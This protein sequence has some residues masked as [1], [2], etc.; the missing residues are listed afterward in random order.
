MTAAPDAKSLAGA[1]QWIRT[2]LRYR[3]KHPALV[4]VLD[5]VE[6]LMERPYR[7]NALL[8]GPAGSGKE[9]LARAI[10]ALMHAERDGAA[11]IEVSLAGRELHEVLAELCG[12]ASGPGQIERADGGTLYIDEIGTLGREV[13]ARVLAAVRGRVRREGERDERRVSVAVV[14]STDVDIEREVVAGRFRHDLYWRIARI[15]LTLPPLAERQADIARTA[16]WIGNRVLEKLGVDRALS[17]E[18]EHD[19]GDIVL[20]PEAVAALTEYDWPGNFRELDAV[21]E[22]ALALYRTGDR[23]TGQ[24]VRAALGLPPT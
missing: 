10:H 2:I 6:R 23:V 15:V 24:D 3:S 18:G 16:V 17:I 4:R 21:L 1:D 11:F 13:Q 14:A 8:L 19:R 9:G 5:V 12:D 22:R 7:T 20:S